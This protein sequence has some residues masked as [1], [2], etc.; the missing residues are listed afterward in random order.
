[1][2]ASLGSTRVTARTNDAIIS[3]VSLIPLHHKRAPPLDTTPSIEVP[4]KLLTHRTHR[5]LLALEQDLFCFS[6]T[7]TTVL[8]W[9]LHINLTTACSYPHL[10]TLQHVL[11]PLTF[12]THTETTRN[13]CTPPALA[14]VASQCRSNTR[15]AP[16]SR[17]ASRL[18]RFANNTHLFT[19][20]IT[21]LLSPAHHAFRSF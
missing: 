19:L 11:A 16:Q 14:T 2:F 21:P 20:L 6:F 13:V 5:P 4:H 3:F 7:W 1:M 15:P 10:H 9:H 12:P 17:L 18:H 8:A